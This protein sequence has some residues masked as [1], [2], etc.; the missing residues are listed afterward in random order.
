MTGKWYGLTLALVLVLALGSAGFAQ[1]NEAPMLAEKVAAGELPP[2][3]ERLPENP[4]VITPY[5]EIGQ[6]GGTWYYNTTDGTNWNHVRMKMYGHSPV[7]WVRDGLGIEGNWVETWESNEDATSWTLNI[8]K[9]IRW[10]DGAPFT[11]ADFMFW[12]ND[13]VLNEEMSDPVPDMLTAGGRPAEITAPDDWTIQ[14]DFAAPSPLLPERLAMWVNAGLAERYIVPSH[15]VKDWHP[16]YSDYEDFET[17]EEI[18]EWWANP[19][20]P[21]LTEWM[22]VE[23]AITERLVL[24]RNPYYYAV[25]PEGNQLPYI[26]RFVATFAEDIEVVKL[27]LM[28][29]ESDFQVRPYLALTDL[30][31]MIDS[32]ESG[33]Y[34][35]KYW[36]SGSG[37]GPM[38]YTNW[39]HWDPEKRDV[40]RTPQFRRAMSVALDRV[41]MQNMQFFG[42][43]TTTTG[44]FSAKAVEFH[45]HPEGQE[46][47]QRWEQDYVHHDPDQARAWLD[48]IGVV[49]QN[50]DG[51]RQ[52]PSGA[53]LVLRIDYNAQADPVY[54]RVNEMAKVDWE[55]VGLRTELNP[56][57]GSALSIL[58]QTAM[59][60]I[61]D[62]WEVG[63]GPNHLVFPQWVVPIDLSR[64]APLYGSWYQQVQ[65][66]TAG[67][68]A[69]LAPRDR[70]PPREEPDS[71]DPVARLQALY[72]IARLEADEETRDAVVR[73]M[74]R[75]HVE[76]GPF[77]LG[78]V[79][80]IPRIVIHNKNMGNVPEQ[81]DLG[82]GGFVNPWIV[83][84]PAITNPGQY[85][86]RQ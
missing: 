44:T 12:W 60:D 48:E 72:D 41:R 67:R 2:V 43:G 18:I 21:V 71:D 84:Y 34:E 13:M 52:L 15:Y 73:D 26:D 9:G 24:E 49:D 46:L 74:I 51:W 50:G 78:T 38:F 64:W 19:G 16:D 37:T 58:D 82:L 25:D 77:F 68:Q 59:F 65:A 63:D 22:P 86:F 81:E 31:M 29:G 6:Y 11:S 5:Y 66:G 75:I 40:Y 55:A 76:E 7:R 62:S 1:Y 32:Q 70:T 57:D 17:F 33:G 20:V 3:E 23:H 47:Y 4:L 69:D 42:L 30:S 27:R 54:I 80:N 85:F 83:P 35:I 36:D 39:N 53:P 8:R 56:M 45:R 10:S 61:R 28:A 14:I 79:S